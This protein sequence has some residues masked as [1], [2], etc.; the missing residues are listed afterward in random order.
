MVTARGE[1]WKRVY[2][3]KRDE[4]VLYPGCGDAH[5]KLYTQHSP[6]KLVL[7]YADFFKIFS[8]IFKWNLTS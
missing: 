5:T 2:P 7:L 1:G 3:P 4:I 8:V 6:Q